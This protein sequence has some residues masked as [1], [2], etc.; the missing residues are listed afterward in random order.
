MTTTEGCERVANYA[1]EFCYLSGRKKVTAVHK[2]NI[3]FF[4][5]LKNNNINNYIIYINTLKY[6][7]N[8]MIGKCVMDYF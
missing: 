1:F 4:Y 5:L 2:A 6:F 8:L 3:M 7:K